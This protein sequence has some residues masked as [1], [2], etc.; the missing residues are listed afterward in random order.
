[1]IMVRIGGRVGVMER[2]R[3]SSFVGGWKI[4][5]VGREGRDDIGR[6]R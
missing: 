2:G 5:G 4:A 1:M 6:R 3:T